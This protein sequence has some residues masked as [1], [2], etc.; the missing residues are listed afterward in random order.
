MM[1]DSNEV[2]KLI[3][4]AL[5]L[6]SIIESVVV[7][8]TMIVLTSKRLKK[9]YDLKK[10][11]KDKQIIVN[12]SPNIKDVLLYIKEENF[13]ERYKEY[14]KNFEKILVCSFDKSYLNT[15]YT[16]I[17]KLKIKNEKRKLLD[18]ILHVKESGGCYYFE[19]NEII[20]KPYYSDATIYHELLHLSSTVINE[21]VSYIGFDQ[22]CDKNSIATGLNEGYTEYLTNKY[23][24]KNDSSSYIYEYLRDISELIEIIVGQDKMQ[25]YYFN[26]DLFSLYFDLSNYIDVKYLD[27]LINDTDYLY[28]SFTDNITLL[29]YDKIVDIFREVNYILIKTYINKLNN[30]DLDENEY[31]KE[32]N[33][34]TNKIKDKFYSGNKIYYIYDEFE[35]EEVIN[36]LK[37]KKVKSK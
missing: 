9:S 12:F 37:N 13:E 21:D 7:S 23:F 19:N 36:S 14:I 2:L 18:I 31:N 15:F 5:P 20:L 28:K 30:F 6:A 16:N 26:S 3:S 27:N 34:F 11:F 8:S 29:Q 35:L 24:V 4:E 32:L 22:T 1:V 33:N 17:N 25:K 10:D